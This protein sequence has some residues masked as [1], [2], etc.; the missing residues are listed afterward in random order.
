VTANPD[1]ETVFITPTLAPTPSDNLTSDSVWSFLG[2][3]FK[4][5]YE[6]CMGSY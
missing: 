1:T 6:V 3:R 5:K 4:C 2:S